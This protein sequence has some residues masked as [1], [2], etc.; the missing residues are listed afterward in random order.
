MVDG[1]FGVG[2]ERGV[3]LLCGLWMVRV[4]GVLCRWKS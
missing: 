2:W 3:R 4:C 1:G